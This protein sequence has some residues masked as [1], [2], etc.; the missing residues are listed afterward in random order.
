M[1]LPKRITVDAERGKV[2]VDGVIFPYALAELQPYPE[3]SRDDVG[4][5][6]LP[7]I[8]DEIVFRAGFK[9]AGER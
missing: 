3:V 8:A 1:L 9:V 4:V 5:V 6:W 2:Y 7:L